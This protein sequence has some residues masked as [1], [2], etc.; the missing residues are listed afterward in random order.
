[1]KDYDY[2]RMFYYTVLFTK[3]VEKKKV[4]KRMLFIRFTNKSHNIAN[5]DEKSNKRIRENNRK[6][7]NT[8]SDV[9]PPATFYDLKQIFY[10]K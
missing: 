4:K 6:K 10:W 2:D 3:T 9:N 7:Y 8:D 5:E 1:M